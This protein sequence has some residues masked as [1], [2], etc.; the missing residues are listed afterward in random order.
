MILEN[1]PHLSPL[2]LVC[3]RAECTCSSCLTRTAPVACVYSASYSLN[4]SQ[5][6]GHTVRRYTKLHTGHL[7]G[8]SNVVTVKLSKKGDRGAESVALSW[9]HHDLERS[10][11]IRSKI[12]PKNNTWT[13]H[14][15]FDNNMFVLSK[16]ILLNVYIAKYIIFKC[17]YL[18]IFVK[19]RFC[20]RKWKTTGIF[21]LPT[22]WKHG[23]KLYYIDQI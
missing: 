15:I 13:I 12:S 2:C 10:S 22:P 1:F 4:A 6:H 20:A 3:F 9:R 14:S 18:N 16:H 7:S 11:L 19:W 5:F 23:L 8:E 17:I 21:W